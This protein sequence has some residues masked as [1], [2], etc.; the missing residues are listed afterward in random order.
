[1]IS[2]NEAF[3]FWNSL[4][5]LEQEEVLDNIT[6]RQYRTGETIKKQ[7]GLYLVSDGYIMVYSNHENGRRRVVFSAQWLDSILFTPTFLKDSNSTYLELI[8]RESSEVCF[9]NYDAWR[10][11]EIKRPEVVDFSRKVLSEQMSALTFVL[12]AKME[13]DLSK[14]LALFLLRHFEKNKENNGSIIRISHEEL[15]DLIGSTREVITRNISVL[16]SEGLIETGRGK[17]RIIDENKLREYANDQK[18]N[19][20]E[21]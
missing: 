2:L 5:E 12:Y 1:M 13:K 17:I 8:S 10:R 4:T 6:I 19:N 15:A 9:I 16:K 14:R 3:P 7:A 18:N 20:W 21:K 11:F